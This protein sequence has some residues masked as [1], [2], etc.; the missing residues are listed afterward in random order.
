MQ[1]KACGGMR[2]ERK[3]EP[4]STRIITSRYCSLENLSRTLEILKLLASAIEIL[5]ISYKSCVYL[6][7]GTFGYVLEE[8]LDWTAVACDSEKF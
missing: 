2:M 1:N 4:I 7:N 6:K 5:F 8:L 3:L